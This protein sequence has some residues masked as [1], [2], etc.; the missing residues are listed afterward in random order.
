MET[1]AAGALRLA[2]A[3]GDVR[4]MELLSRFPSFYVEAPMKGFTPLMAAV[5][6]GQEQAVLWLL[7]NGASH[8]AIKEDG[9]ND[10][11]LHYAAAKGN[12]AIVQMLLA[13]GADV[14]ATNANGKYAADV[15]EANGHL[16]VAQYLDLVEDK[17]TRLPDKAPLMSTAT[18]AGAQG[19]FTHLYEPSTQCGNSSGGSSP[20]SGD[21]A[22]VL[23]AG[24]DQSPLPTD[25][26]E[27]G[28]VACARLVTLHAVV[29]NPP[30]LRVAAR[31][32][33][34]RQ[35]G[36][37][38]RS[39]R[40]AAAS[41]CSQ[42]PSGHATALLARPTSAVPCSQYRPRSTSPPPPSPATIHICP[43]SYST[44][45][46]ICPPTV[47][48]PSPYLP[49]H[50]TQPLPISAR[51]PYSTPAHICPPTVL[52]PCPPF[53]LRRCVRPS[54]QPAPAASRAGTAPA[55]SPCAP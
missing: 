37:S 34:P 25:P 18:W 28:A 48:N 36:C 2:A 4:T 27:V 26:F 43:P 13:F 5:I 54:S 55:P 19:T 30:F 14:S 20:V 44:P 45:P 29:V 3:R 49:A 39:R 41:I 32:H 51:P 46:H 31:E 9:W 21:V 47:L 11:V 40:N 23:T 12:M 38:S 52:N 50:R 33:M 10:S 15:A 8:R 7:Q 53:P 42:Y 17:K 24:H 22:V 6:Q 35:H 16:Q 1:T